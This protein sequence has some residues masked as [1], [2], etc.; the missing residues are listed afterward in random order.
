MQRLPAR[1]GRPLKAASLRAP[2]DSESDCTTLAAG[3]TSG[4]AIF[5]ACPFSG[6]TQHSV[7]DPTLH[8]YLTTLYQLQKL[9][10]NWMRRLCM[11]TINWKGWRRRFSGRTSKHYSLISVEG[12]KKF[13]TSLSQDSFIMTWT[14]YNSH[15][16][17]LNKPAL[18]II[19][20]FSFSYFS[21][22]PHPEYSPLLA[23]H[24]LW[25]M[26]VTQNVSYWFL[27][28]KF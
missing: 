23:M 2:A 24:P 25:H 10:K 22:D 9:V 1:S 20:P 12:L 13:I 15:A 3:A 16:L 8:C 11:I 5:I 4:P 7:C 17:P 26:L 14:R 28:I 18:W 21:C 19:F 27:W 6:P